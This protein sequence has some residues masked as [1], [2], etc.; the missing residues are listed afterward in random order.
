MIDFFSDYYYVAKYYNS[1]RIRLLAGSVYVK[2][3]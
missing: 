1:D 3:S 2:D